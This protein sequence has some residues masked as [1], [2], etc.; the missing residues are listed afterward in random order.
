MEIRKS[1]K[2]DYKTPLFFVV[3]LMLV[4]G[5]VAVFS[6]SWPEGAQKFNDGYFFIK[7]HLSHIA[8]GF[9]LMLFA[10]RVDYR[11]YKKLTFFFYIFALALNF[12]L[13]TNLNIVENLYGQSRTLV[14]GPVHFM[15]SDLMKA[16]AILYISA[17]ISNNQRSIKTFPTIA[18]IFLMIIIPV[19][20]ILGKDF[21]TAGVLAVTLFAIFFVGGLPISYIIP[22]IMGVVL[23]G[24]Y[25]IKSD[26]YRSERINVFLD[27]FSDPLGRGWQII[28]SLY[29]LA[30]GGLFGSGLG[31]SISKYGD[32]S[33]IYNDF[34]FALIGEE[35]GF[36]GAA[37]IVILVTAFL[38][39]GL[40][41]A[42]NCK[43]I[44]GRLVAVGFTILL[45]T[46]ALANIMVA[47]KLM[48]VTGIPLPFIS[49]GGT[50]MIMNMVMVGIL[51]N[52]SK[53][54]R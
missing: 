51:L 1:I 28:H 7:R 26:G 29:A 52:I 44:Y 37:A 41:I 19:V 9:I 21:S 46:Q 39:Y 32:I 40:R 24:V 35:F 5:S 20:I 16:A 14:L 18:K 25:G 31:M 8:M 43:D 45:T 49:Y 48:P 47:I 6:A 42:I 34:I 2:K 27:P 15:P 54:C 17:L 23:I 38:I 3:V 36:I 22:L 10:Y 4:A 33:S 50:S 30:M 53:N 13:Y 12:L 11:H